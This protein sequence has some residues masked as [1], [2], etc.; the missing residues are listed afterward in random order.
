[1]AKCYQAGSDPPL[2]WLK[3][4]RLSRLQYRLANRN[5]MPRF[6]ARTIQRFLFLQP[7]PRS[8]P[9]AQ[10]YWGSHPR[11]LWLRVRP[12]LPGETSLSSLPDAESW[13]PGFFY[14]AS[15]LESDLSAPPSPVAVL[16]MPGPRSP[17]IRPS[18]PGLRFFPRAGQTTHGLLPGVCGGMPVSLSRNAAGPSFARR[19][20]ALSKCWAFRAERRVP[21]G[22]GNRLFFRPANFF[23][24]DLLTQSER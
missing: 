1:M 21:R 5:R 18:H 24:W 22:F 8:S 20:R 16:N 9:R 6:P 7:W 19:K 14:E 15:C 10:V 12:R 13:R 17:L 23:P 11:R 2:N 4:F 3:R